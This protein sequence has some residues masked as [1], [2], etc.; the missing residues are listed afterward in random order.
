MSHILINMKKEEIISLLSEWNFWGRGLETGKE[1]TYTHE[2][3]EML[4][5]KVNK[6]VSVFGVRRAGKSYILRQ[7]AKRLSEKYGKKNVLYVNF[8]EIG[9]GE[10]NVDLLNNIYFAYT[11]LI[12]P[13]MKP[14][15]LLDEIQEI[16]G[17]EKWVRSLHEKDAAKFV[18][19]GSSAKLMSEELATLL[20]GRDVAIEVFPLDF[21]E[22][23]DFKEIEWKREKRIINKKD[24][25]ISL[26]EF[27]EFGGFPEIVETE[28]TT[29]KKEI[30][31][32]Y[33]DTILIKDV[34]KRYGIRDV[35]YLEFL[36]NYYLSNIS[37]LISFNRLS[38]IIR[39]PVKTVERYSKYLESSRMI[40]SIPKFSF[41]LKE[42]EVAPRKIYSI[43]IGISNAVGFRFMENY[44]KLIE[45]LVAISL[46]H[47]NAN[48]FYFKDYQQR[49]VDF[50]I[51]E[52]LEVKQL[53]QVTY[54]SDKD[55]VEQREIRSLLKAS[56]LLNCK[57]LLVIT[58]D[59]EDEQ[60]VK[61]KRIR[62]MPLWKW[63]LDVN[64]TRR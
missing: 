55:E 43:D 63:L 58:W 64:S 60:E 13:Q 1:R 26:R 46:L 59:Y 38:K 28:N 19:S 27:L 8:E 10:R 15:L 29:K 3:V 7:V 25:I 20:A 33:Y 41:S 56:D 34:Q 17:W 44:G 52:G 31:R 16:K 4:E 2:I 45:N 6:I 48:I 39:I 14:F 12:R 32:R 37:A 62:F 51:K 42:R 54:A 22:Y 40:F 23:L 9:L 21:K 53:I 47:T 61:G 11:E 30:L 24:I 50:V 5:G 57:N 35:K 36:A 18:V 49:E